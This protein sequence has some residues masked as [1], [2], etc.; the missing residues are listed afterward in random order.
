[1]FLGGWGV[2]RFYLG[3]VGTG[4]LKLVTGGGL[5][6][7]WLIDVILVLSGKATTKSGQPLADPP[8]NKTGLIVASV[9]VVVLALPILLFIPLVF[10]HG[11]Q[12][13]AGY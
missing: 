6:V 12:S 2:D 10:L 13:T 1:M 11:V 8:A 9:V 3:K 7:W 5:G 4:I